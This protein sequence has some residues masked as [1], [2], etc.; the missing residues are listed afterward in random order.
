MNDKELI[1]AIDSLAGRARRQ[2]AQEVE[3]WFNALSY[4]LARTL[5]EKNKKMLEGELS[6]Q[7]TWMFDLN[8]GIYKDFLRNELIRQPGEE[9]I[10]LDLLRTVINQGQIKGSI[11][12]QQ[13]DNLRRWTT[14]VENE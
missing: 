12:P 2:N 1:E 6:K 13:A 7:A 8:E 10:N 3:R 14:E 11:T 4:D 9:R 5:L